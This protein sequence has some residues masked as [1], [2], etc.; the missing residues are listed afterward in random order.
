MALLA[1]G[2]MPL[3]SGDAPAKLT[4]DDA[5]KLKSPADVRLHLNLKPPIGARG[6]R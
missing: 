5:Q 4:H 1:C 2:G 6:F 3:V